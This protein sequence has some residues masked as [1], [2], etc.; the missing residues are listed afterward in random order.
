MKPKLKILYIAYDAIGHVNA[1]ISVAEILRDRG[2]KIIFAIDKSW[3]GQL[4]KYGFEEQLFSDPE[5]AGIEDPTQYWAN[6]LNE[7]GVMKS[8]PPIEKVIKIRSTILSNHLNNMKE[9]DLIMENILKR[10]K[11]DIIIIDNYIGFPS[12]I[13]CGIPWVLS[14]SFN[15][16]MFIDDERT[17]PPC[18][19]DN[20]SN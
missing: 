9:T 4:Q 14:C 13:G 15:P 18:S 2:H 3:R 11:P 5:K 10:I 20:S 19:G 6:L 16:L 17:P 12:V 1:C 8:L 7:I